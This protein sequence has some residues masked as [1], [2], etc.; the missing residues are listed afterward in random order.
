MSTYWFKKLFNSIQLIMMFEFDIAKNS[1][2]KQENQTKI[3]LFKGPPSSLSLLVHYVT[4]PDFDQ[5]G[6]DGAFYKRGLLL[7]ISHLVRCRSAVH[8]NMH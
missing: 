6:D 4:P 1:H 2:R 8:V 7:K 5:L 3:F